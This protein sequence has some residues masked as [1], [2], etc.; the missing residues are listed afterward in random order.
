MKN[1]AAFISA[2]E[3][4]LHEEKNKKIKKKVGRESSFE[5]HCCC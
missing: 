2:R 5:A 4:I 3:H 1:M